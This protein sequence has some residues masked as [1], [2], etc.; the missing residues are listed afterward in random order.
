MWL[1]EGSTFEPDEELLKD[2]VGF[3]YLVTE[4]ATG[5]KYIGKKL[6]WKPKTLPVTKTRLK[7]IKTKVQSDW[8]KYYGSNELLKELVKES[9]GVGYKREILRMCKSKGDCSYYEAKYQFQYEV[10]ESKEYYNQFI[11][12]K[13]HAKHLSVNMKPKPIKKKK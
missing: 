7:K 9:G 12:C 5:M 2:L 4:E 3:V 11:G 1:Y 6:F 10:L 8:M 13:I